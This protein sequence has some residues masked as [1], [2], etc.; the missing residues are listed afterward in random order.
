MIN[1]LYRIKF[2]ST[3]E[4]YV[5]PTN[6]VE[7][8]LC[9]IWQ[10][11]L[12]IDKVSI[13]DNFFRIGGDSILSIQVS[14]R[15]RQAG[16][17]CQVKDIFEHKT[18]ARLAEQIV[19][20]DSKVSFKTEQGILSGESGLLPVQKWF[21]DK[22]NEGVFEKFS[23]L[24]HSFLVKVPK[25]NT[26]K[27][28]AIVEQLVNYHDVL[29]MKY[30][31][32]QESE[33]NRIQWKQV[34]QSKIVLPEIKTLDVSKHDKAEIQEILTSWQN[35]FDLEQGFLFQIGYLYGYKDG[36]ARL[37]FALHH[38]IVDG[39][40]WRIL[41]EDVKSLYEGR[42]L[43]S[44]GSS[45]RQWVECL[46]AYP[47]LHL[48]EETYWEQLVKGLPTYQIGDI[49]AE[50]HQE[51]F[52][53]D[54]E[55]TTFLLQNAS[56][57]YHT[58]INDLLLTALAFA[59]KEI[60]KNDIQG[61]TLEGHGRE[62]ID[63][64]IDHSHT[65]GWFT[66]LFP[67]KLEVKSSLKESIQSVKESLRGIPNKG[68]GFGVFA[69][70]M[71]TNYSYKDLPPISFNYLGQFASQLDDWHITSEDSGSSIC[72]TNKDHNIFNING[73]VSNGK[74]EF[75]IVSSL[76]KDM[77]KLLSDCYKAQ[78]IRIIEHCN[79]KIENKESSYT[80]SDF[81]LAKVSQSLLDKLQLKAKSI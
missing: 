74:L 13:N 27:L 1:E 11:V 8:S 80:P 19:K 15:I 76:G 48:T 26:N 42:A 24:N 23:H 36:S 67:V 58:E 4:R 54:K 43:Q 25:I 53:L 30:V 55:L 59:L 75:I 28:I 9:N 21:L 41:A 12:G 73:M 72:T 77:A 63:S 81:K 14:S 6:E 57:V 31:K 71:S 64:F 79:E 68:I 46:S 62:S 66:S 69:N 45:Y 50:P 3:S 40:S 5:S 32:V 20:K 39:V 44:K 78:I 2:G 33:T 37:F 7:Q 38:L 10:T 17:V 47:Q 60:N 49:A 52:E 35:N 22:V 65:I 70:T 56:K 16:F 61:I 18:I 51:S 29:R 34:Y